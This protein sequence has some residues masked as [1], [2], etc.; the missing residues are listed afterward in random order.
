M[1]QAARAH[2]YETLKTAN[3]KYLIDRPD[4]KFE[5]FCTA[6]KKLKIV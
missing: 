5:F 1:F 4:L 3:V 6:K 2:V